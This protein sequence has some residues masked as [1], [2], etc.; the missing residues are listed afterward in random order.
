MNHSSCCHHDHKQAAIVG[1]KLKI[2]STIFVVVLAT[3]YFTPALHPLYQSIVSYASLIWWAVALGLILGG[4]IDYF[5]PEAFIYNYL[6][7]KKASTLFFAVIVGFLL[8]ACSHGILALAIQLHKKGA[9]TPAVITFL[10]A[11]PWANLPITFLLFGFFG[12]KAILFILAA[13]VIALVTGFGY[14]A[15]EHYQLIEASPQPKNRESIE[16]TNLKNFSLKKSIHGVGMGTIS[17]MNMVLWWLLI[18]FLLAAVIG[19]YVPGHIFLHYFGADFWGLILT[20]AVATVIEVCSEGSSPIAFEIYNQIG[21][22]GNPF[23]FLMAGV[24]T[25]YTEIGLLWTNIGK[26]TALWLPVI[27]VPQVLLFAYLFNSFL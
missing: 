18:G 12:W 2:V 26:K 11:S 5:V 9:S 27:T 7:Q 22:L 10:L 3:S 6:G 19:A 8:S 14:M 23:V 24:V 15:L 25:D 1:K 13:M 16:W 4:L 21:T 20:L 17:L